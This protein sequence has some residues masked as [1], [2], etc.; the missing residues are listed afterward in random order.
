[1][2]WPQLLCSSQPHPTTVHSL[3]KTLYRRSHFHLLPEDWCHSLVQIKIKTTNQ[4]LLFALHCV[5]AH[6]LQSSNPNSNTEDLPE[7]RGLLTIGS[8]SDKRDENRGI[9]AS[10]KGQL[11]CIYATSNC[12]CHCCPCQRQQNKLGNSSFHR[13]MTAKATSSLPRHEA[14]LQMQK[15][16]VTQDIPHQQLSVFSQKQ[17]S[18]NSAEPVL[19]ILTSTQSSHSIQ[20]SH[21]SHANQPCTPQGLTC[22]SESRQCLSLLP[23]LLWLRSL[24]PSPLQFLSI[25][26]L[27]KNHY[28]YLLW[29]PCFSVIF[30]TVSSIDSATASIDSPKTHF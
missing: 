17:V 27:D 13:T 7:T 18:W 16:D 24:V 28:K 6:L 10:V 9:T 15:G 30:G 14:L 1:M 22:L 23:F 20:G 2:H 5:S 12:C 29:V 8:R 3:I 21:Q 26:S 11:L 4:L 25:I 19:I